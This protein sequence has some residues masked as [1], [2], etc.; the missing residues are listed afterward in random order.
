MCMNIYRLY[1]VRMVYIIIIILVIYIHR[2]VFIY[3][4]AICC[5]KFL[6]NE[7]CNIKLCYEDEWPKIGSN[8]NFII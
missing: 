4:V 6:T 2:N 7:V 1:I 8:I 5:M 3:H